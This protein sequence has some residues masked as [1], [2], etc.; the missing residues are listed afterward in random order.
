MNIVRKGTRSQL[1]GDGPVDSA[2][3]DS[4]VKLDV[5]VYVSMYIANNSIWMIL[6]LYIVWVQL[7]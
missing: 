2:T 3:P 7:Y 6:T 4:I 5:I 1:H